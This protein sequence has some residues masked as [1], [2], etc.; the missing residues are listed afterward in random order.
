M[1][2]NE[3]EELEKSLIRWKIWSGFLAVLLLI[4]SIWLLFYIY[5]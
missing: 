4:N 1:D 3:I 5:K 2:E